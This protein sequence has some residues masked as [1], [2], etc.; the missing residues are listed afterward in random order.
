MDKQ[1][2]LEIVALILKS[3]WFRYKKNKYQGKIIKQIILTAALTRKE[4]KE[5]IKRIEDEEKQIEDEDKQQEENEQ[6]RIIQMSS[7]L[8][9]FDYNIF[10]DLIIRGDIKGRDLLTL[11]KVCKKF[12]EFCH[13]GFEIK[14]KNGE[15]IRI[16]DQYLFRFLLSRNGIKSEEDRE[17]KEVYIEET[18]GRKFFGI[19][20]NHYGQLAL[21][22]QESVEIITRIPKM[23]NI[24][25]ISCGG[26]H[27]L[28]LDNQGRVWA[29]GENTCGQ[30]GLGDNKHRRV[31]TLILTL[32]NIVQISTRMHHSLCLDNQGRVWSFGNNGDG[33]LGLGDS[34]NR[35][36]PTMIPNFNNICQ[37]SA[38]N[39]HCLCL[40][41]QGRV[42]SFGANYSGQLGLE[43]N[44]SRTVPTLIPNLEKIIDV[45]TGM[46]SFC[47]NEEGKVWSFGD[48]MFGQLG[49][50]DNVNK[51]LPCQVHSLN[52]CNIIQVSLSN[53]HSLCLDDQGRVWVF[54]YN[55]LGE[56]GLGDYINRNSPTYVFANLQNIVQVSAGHSY[57]LCLT[58]QGRVWGFGRTVFEGE[59]EYMKNIPTFIPC[60]EDVCQVR[61]GEASSIFLKL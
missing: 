14:N 59:Y 38:G 13:R 6:K 35:Y 30:L 18:I 1:E 32:E 45:I 15:V 21:G 19:G 17:P 43:D 53:H 58:D 52:D 56:L 40:D 33:E 41:N 10:I 31:P 48:N 49:L 12:R 9:K 34:Q 27:S 42:W 61:T 60:L 55:E 22:P 36:F 47:I 7:I 5:V 28:C 51:Y 37:V 54:G 57:S 26:Y 8:E 23:E 16:D 11:C 46:N 20:N 2:V 39:F 44:R 50:G 25:D 24:I 29:F 3:S 4:N